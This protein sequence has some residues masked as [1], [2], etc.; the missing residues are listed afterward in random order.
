MVHV[1]LTNYFTEENVIAPLSIEEQAKI[2]GKVTQEQLE[3]EAKKAK[4]A[5][6]VTGNNMNDDDIGQEHVEDVSHSQINKTA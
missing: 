3:A 5:E 1:K 6:T 4:L 2:E